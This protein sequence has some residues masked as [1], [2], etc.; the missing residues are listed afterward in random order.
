MTDLLEHSPICKQDLWTSARRSLT[1]EGPMPP[2][3]KAAYTPVLIEFVDIKNK[4]LDPG[5]I[6][7]L[8]HW[9]TNW[10]RKQSVTERKQ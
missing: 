9:I 5:H 3:K 1:S 10:A 2:A 7:V 6:T 8:H 4:Y